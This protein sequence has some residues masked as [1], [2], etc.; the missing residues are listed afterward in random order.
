MFIIYLQV[1]VFPRNVFFRCLPFPTSDYICANQ[2]KRTLVIIG[3]FTSKTPCTEWAHYPASQTR[4][5]CRTD[6]TPTVQRRKCMTAVP[7]TRPQPLPSQPPLPFWHWFHLI[8]YTYINESLFNTQTKCVSLILQLHLHR[9]QTR[10]PDFFHTHRLVVQCL[11]CHFKK[12]LAL[13]ICIL[14]R[15]V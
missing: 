1:V 4:G 8:T 7:P 9:P 13:K 14:F 12:A 5:R 10:L 15:T 3:D 2:S 6:R 11:V